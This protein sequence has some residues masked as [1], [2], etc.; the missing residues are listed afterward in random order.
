MVEIKNERLHD[1]DMFH[2]GVAQ[3]AIQILFIDDPDSTQTVVRTALVCITIVVNVIT[4]S[5]CIHVP[6]VVGSV[7]V[8]ERQRNGVG[9]AV[10]WCG[11]GSVMVW[12]GQRN[13]VGGAA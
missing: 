2:A 9:G 3:N 13:G 1:I 12:E 11:R 7:M 8:W 10:Q 4:T 5:V 6:L